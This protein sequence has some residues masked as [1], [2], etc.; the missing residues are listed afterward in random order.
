MRRLDE[1]RLARVPLSGERR[2]Y[3][4]FAL[5]DEGGSGERYILPGGR[6]SDLA[7]RHPTRSTLLLPVTF[8][9]RGWILVL[10]GPEI[11]MLLLLYN[12][13]AIYGRRVRF[14]FVSRSERLDSYC[15]SDEIYAAHRELAEF[16]LIRRADTLKER[17]RGRL[18]A[19]ARREPI[20]PF[21]FEVNP[22]GLD[23]Q[24][25]TV[26]KK[27]LAASRS[28]PHLGR[29]ERPVDYPLAWMEPRAENEESLNSPDSGLGEHEVIP[30]P[31]APP[32]PEDGWF[33]V[34]DSEELWAP[35][36][37]DFQEQRR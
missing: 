7:R 11:A 36:E 16:G 2:Q 33:E 27:R 26:V 9:T 23:R 32:D 24:A 3:S 34:T 18:P 19:D 20:P 14:K 12:L 1:L 17:R 25:L 8:F 10:T 4:E 37:S 35:D 30:P 5:L 28:A 22:D 15:I 21:R 13:D 6:H 29:R 31:V